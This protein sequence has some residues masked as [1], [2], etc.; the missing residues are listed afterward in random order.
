MVQNCICCSSS[1]QWLNV[2]WVTVSENIIIFKWIKVFTNL[3]VFNSC[4]KEINI[5]AFIYH[6]DARHK[7]FTN[8]NK[9]FYTLIFPIQEHLGEN[10]EKM[11]IS[12]NLAWSYAKSINISSRGVNTKS[13]RSKLEYLTSPCPDLVFINTHLSST[14]H[15]PQFYNLV[16]FI[17]DNDSLSISFNL[18]LVVVIHENFFY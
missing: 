5:D 17:H 4:E 8:C 10:T 18:I 14:L 13:I 9:L 16:Q 1:I 15:D 6:L 12:I 3:L 2:F 11:S 7:S